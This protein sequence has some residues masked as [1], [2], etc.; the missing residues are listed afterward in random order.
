MLLHST[1]LRKSTTAHHTTLH[2]LPLVLVNVGTWRQISCS[3]T[4]NISGEECSLMTS[5]QICEL[6]N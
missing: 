2:D 4:F 5:S 3:G 1:E 6:N